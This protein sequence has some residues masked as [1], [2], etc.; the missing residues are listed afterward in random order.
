M[1]LFINNIQEITCIHAAETEVY[2]IYLEARQHRL[3]HK[4]HY[5]DKPYMVSE[6][7]DWGVLC[8]ECWS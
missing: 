3:K 1:T 2:D 4:A 6:Y 5:P 8:Y 7:G